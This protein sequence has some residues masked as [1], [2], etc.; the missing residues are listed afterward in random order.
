MRR[1]LQAREAPTAGISM[2]RAIFHA[3]RVASIDHGTGII[4]G[5]NRALPAARLPRD[6]H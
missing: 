1:D 2:W 3:Y 6:T 4:V 5:A